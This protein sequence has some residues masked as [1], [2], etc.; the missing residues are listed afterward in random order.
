M[1]PNDSTYP[2]PFLDAFREAITAAGWKVEHWEGDSARCTDSKG[3]PWQLTLDNLYRRLQRHEPENWAEQAADFL[4]R[5]EAPKER[6]ALAD[7]SDRLL[8]RVGLPFRGLPEGQRPWSRPIPR[9][10]LAVSLIIDHPET[11]THVTETMV[12][13]SGRPG[14]DWLPLALANL[15]ARTPTG[16][17]ETIDER[18]GLMM[19]SL[20][21]GYDSARALL[22][23]GLVPQAGDLGCFVAIPNRES[24]LLLPM[25]PRGLASLHMLKSIT[26]THFAKAPYPISDDVF[27][28]R[29]GEWHPIPIEVRDGQLS[30][31]VPDELGEL[32]DRLR[33]APRGEG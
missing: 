23:D 17:A 6:A 30:V 9:T 4:R 11:M 16:A 2:E 28:V 14:E 13:E 24:L 21:D 25:T 1:K 29:G 19:C 22:V 8:V 15:R 33:R 32:I 27:W 26:Q 5:M 20:S 7:A 3:S 18:S 10:P 31:G 12:A